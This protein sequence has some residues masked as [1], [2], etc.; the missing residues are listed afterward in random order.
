MT[1][2]NFSA[3]V[4]LSLP[5][6]LSSKIAILSYIIVIL[7]AVIALAVIVMLKEG[8]KERLECRIVGDINATA[9]GSITATKGGSSS[10]SDDGVE[11]ERFCM[12]S[13]IERRK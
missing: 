3:S 7:G 4:L 12:L 1:L 8:N 5:A 9:S 10:S 11:G 13:E 6:V 2:L